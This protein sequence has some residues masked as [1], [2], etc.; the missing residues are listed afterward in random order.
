M[1]YTLPWWSSHHIS[2]CLL[3]VAG[4]EVVKEAEDLETMERFQVVE[5]VE[6]VPNFVVKPP[7]SYK[8][9]NV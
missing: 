1:Q 8:R 2:S 5:T 6:A 3:A 7:I 4:V 9:Y